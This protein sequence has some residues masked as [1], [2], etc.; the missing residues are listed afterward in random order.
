MGHAQ[1]KEPSEC[2]RMNLEMIINAWKSSKIMNFRGHDDH[3]SDNVLEVDFPR[4]LSMAHFE[5]T[6]LKIYQ[7]DF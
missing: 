3:H 6:E 5:A 1:V 2:C 4:L 7:N